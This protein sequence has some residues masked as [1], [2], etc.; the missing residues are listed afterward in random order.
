MIASWHPLTTGVSMGAC[1]GLE[2]AM[3]CHPL[4]L[5]LSLALSA[6]AAA[7]SPG[8]DPASQARL[9]AA[10]TWITTAVYEDDDVDN[11][12]AAMYPGVVGISRWDADS[13]RFEY[14][15]PSNGK[16]RRAQGGGGWFFFTGDARHQVT[17]P[18]NGVPLPRRMQVLDAETFT[19]SRRVPRGM[20]PGQP[21]VTLHVVHKPYTGPWQIPAVPFAPPL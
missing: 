11:D 16:S 10:R 20:Q 4:L 8:V 14:F 6:P 9:L 13:N 17:V 3:R 18:D 15:D 12:K 19:Y 2:P 7:A 5:L 1:F 21:M